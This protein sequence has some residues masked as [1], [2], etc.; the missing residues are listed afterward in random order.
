M[1]N[2]E[3]IFKKNKENN[4]NIIISESFNHKKLN[5]LYKTDDKNL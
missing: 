1:I 4:E 3:K 5:T 2:N